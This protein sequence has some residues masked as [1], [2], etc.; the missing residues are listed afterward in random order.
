MWLLPRLSAIGP[1]GGAQE[2]DINAVLGVGSVAADAELDAM[3]EQAEAQILSMRS[4]LGPHA[5][6]VSAGVRLV[7]TA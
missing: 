4:L 3:K 2:D 6:L 1:A 5:R 7:I